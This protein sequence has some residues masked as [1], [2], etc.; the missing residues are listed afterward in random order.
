MKFGF[1]GRIGALPL[2]VSRTEGYVLPPTMIP[3]F[4]FNN[5]FVRPSYVK[6]EYFLFYPE[7]S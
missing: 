1:F 2:A 7:P 4:N 6:G 3:W 5:S